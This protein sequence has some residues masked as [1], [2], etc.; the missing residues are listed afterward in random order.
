MHYRQGFWNKLKLLFIQSHIV[1]SITVH[2]VLLL[3]A[4]INW[5]HRRDVSLIRFIIDTE[6][7]SN[8]LIT[9]L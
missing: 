5:L 7:I 8:A 6:D 3:L 1:G 4:L 2:T 9:A